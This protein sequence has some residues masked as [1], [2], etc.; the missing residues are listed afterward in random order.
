M[1]LNTKYIKHHLNHLVF[2][3]NCVNFGCKKFWTIN[4]DTIFFS[5][6]LG[7]VI[8]I[9]F[10]SV[11]RKLDLFAPGIFQSLSEIVLEL[12]NSQIR[13]CFGKDKKYSF[14]GSLALTIF[15]WIL[16]MNLMD[17][18]PLDFFS[19]FLHFIGIN[20]IKIVPTNDL[21]M[22]FSLSFSV[23]MLFIFFK[24]KKKNFFGFLK[25]MCLHPFHNIFLIP[26]NV[27]LSF[28]DLIGK[29]ISLS[30]RLFG[31]LYAGELIFILF[32]TLTVGKSL[33]LLSSKLV[34][35]F[36]QCILMFLWSIFHIFIA[37]LQ[38]FIFMVLTIVYLSIAYEK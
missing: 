4:L 33:T 23:F 3:L 10:Y 12:V 18:V 30:L 27:I 35:V 14:I 29:P 17:V 37:I 21:N 2:N 7:L 11:T 16:L 32:S 8:V 22:T 9:F 38:A 5:I 36:F 25:E 13:D 26:F 34:I 20:Y 15:T 6:F 19:F 28:L 1:D 31:N 24:I